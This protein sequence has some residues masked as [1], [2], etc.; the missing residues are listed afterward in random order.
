MTRVY[1]FAPPT[2]VISC[3]LFLT[4]STTAQNEYVDSLLLVL[5]NSKEDTNKVEILNE[6]CWELG[7]SHPKKAEKYGKEGVSLSKKIN[8]DRGQSVGYYYLAKLYLEQG[9]PE[10]AITATTKALEIDTKLNNHVAVASDHNQLGGCYK[11]LGNF[12]TATFHYYKSIA[13]FEQVGD[14]YSA[15][16]VKLNIAN[17]AID[18]NEPKKALKLA[19]EARIEFSI[20]EDNIMLS[21]AFVMEAHALTKLDRNTEA[22]ALYRKSLSISLKENNP[23]VEAEIY[24]NIGILFND[25]NEYDSAI[26]YLKMSQE[27]DEALGRTF[28]QAISEANLGLV[29]MNKDDEEKSIE[30][31]NMSIAHGREIG[32]LKDISQMMEY[33]AEIYYEGGDYKNAYDYFLLSHQLKDTLLTETKM[34]KILEIQEKYETEKKARQIA[35][36]KKERDATLAK[37]RLVDTVIYFSIGI[38]LLLLIVVYFF[39]R[40]RRAKENQRKAELE[41]KVLRAQMNPHFIF[42]SLNS[43]QR[44]FIERDEDLANDYISDFGKLL[45]IIMDNSG[46]NTVSIKDEIDTLKLYLDIEMIRLDGK[47]NYHFD[48]DPNLDLINNFIPPLIIQ[49]FVENAIWH[50]ILPKENQEQGEITVSINRHSDKLIKCSIIDNGIGI[51]QSLA[52]KTDTTHHSKGMNL[53]QERLGNPIQTEELATGGTKVTLLIPLK[54]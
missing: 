10:L 1:C 45:R 14:L 15:A 44:I 12:E 48:L 7:I 19:R 47:I 35:V 25:I 49:P 26:Y 23:Y 32:E 54:Q 51:S 42:N 4:F 38:I 30:Y 8:F 3:L 2:F 29:Y 5:K 52:M 16:Q 36:L 21:K 39:L 31:I 18:Q 40:Q 13:I 27:M 33:A 43:I 20:R 24:N 9:N 46:K 37:S 50:G 41:H 6:L 28:F 22:L 34:E 53:T 11:A 17:F